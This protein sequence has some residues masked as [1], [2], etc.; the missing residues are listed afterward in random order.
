MKHLLLALLLSL[1]PITT[2]LSE[3]FSAEGISLEIPRGFDGPLSQDLN[4]AAVYAF[5]K[6]S[7]APEVRTMFQISIYD[8]GKALP[9][10]SNEKMWAGTDKSVLA[11]LK[12]VERRRTNFNQGKI[13][14]MHLGGIP[15]SKI[16]WSGD[17]EGV[18]A[19][20]VMY[21]VMV[22]SKLVSL[23]TQETSGKSTP[24]MSE[25]IRAIESLS[26]K[27]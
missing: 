27:Q 2:G 26:I 4:G 7:T 15:A 9:K 8:T 20:G 13:T 17:Y 6:S 14:H 24:N 10:L 22:G 12:G 19:N 25:A 18:P 11:M 5:T 3:N 16:S 23:H 21:C 1:V